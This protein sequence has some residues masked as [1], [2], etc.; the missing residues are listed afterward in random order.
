MVATGSPR[1]TQAGAKDRE[2][3]RCEDRTVA[4]EQ[5]LE[6]FRR[7]LPGLLADPANVGRFALVHGDAVAGLYATFDEALAA[8]YE[9]FELKPFLVKEV[10]AHEI[11][12]YFSRNL[13]CP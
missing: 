4:L 8:G 12:S 5:E 7:E 3:S 9:K 1:E 2:G 10:V 6:T 13:R 11:P